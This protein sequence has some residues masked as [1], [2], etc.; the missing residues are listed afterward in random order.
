MVRKR[1]NNRSSKLL[2][3]IKRSVTRDN[4]GSEIRGPSD[5]PM[6]VQAPWWPLT[7]V[8][9]ATANTS[10]SPSKVYTAI[11]NQ[12]P[13]FKSPAATTELR[14]ISVRA[15][16]KD[17]PIQM[18]INNLVNGQMVQQL[19]DMPAPM[20]F[21]HVGWKYGKTQQIIS[22]NMGDTSVELF[23]VNLRQAET[24][25]PCIVYLHCLVKLSADTTALVMDVLE[26]FNTSVDLNKDLSYEMV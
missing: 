3:R 25:N 24:K 22:H 2:S 7:V 14:L 15:W 12:I 13:D 8:T 21:A 19:A 1:N 20:T 10:F 18:K 16:R 6:I 17:G 23:D 9:A 4:H 11:V 5:P 26:R